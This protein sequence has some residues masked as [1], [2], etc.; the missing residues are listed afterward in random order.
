MIRAI[1]HLLNDQPLAV[2]LLEPPSPGDISVI[3]TNL[4]TIDG[5]KPVF[6]DFANSTFAF[7]MAAI[8]FIEVLR[9]GEDGER[10]AV[11]ASDDAPEPEDLEIDEDFLRRVREA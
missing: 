1:L 4:R 9:V 10:M 8:R 3:C 2:D 11:V 7:P 6:I 5:K